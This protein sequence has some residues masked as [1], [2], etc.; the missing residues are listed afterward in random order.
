ML[1]TT[2]IIVRKSKL[3]RREWI[4]S[5]SIHLTDW[6]KPSTSWQ[7]CQQDT[8][9]LPC[10]GACRWMRRWPWK[11]W[12]PFSL[13]AARWNSPP[14]L[15]TATGRTAPGVASGS[16]RKSHTGHTWRGNVW[17]LEQR[18]RC[19]GMELRSYMKPP[20][21]SSLNRRLKAYVHQ[22]APDMGSLLLLRGSRSSSRLL[23]LKMPTLAE[24]FS[25]GQQTAIKKHI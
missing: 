22:R 1:N 13:L 12:R 11:W 21:N 10:W 23:L 16:R 20:S 7:P 6:L 15:G 4:T 17:W 18:H 8:L 25:T 3:Q 5:H 14:G 19:G 2:Q 24:L 9:A